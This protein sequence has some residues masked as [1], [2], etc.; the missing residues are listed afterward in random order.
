MSKKVLV[1]GAAG[2]IGSHTLIELI[3]SGAYEVIALDNFSNST[4][5]ALERVKKI[6]NSEFKVLET[7]LCNKEHCF[8]LLDKVGKID[9]VI[10]FAA[11]KAVGESVLNPL[12]YYTNNLVSLL[13]LLEYCKVNQITNFV[14]SSS[15]SIYGNADE[16]PVTETSPIKKAESPYANTKQMGEEIIEH[17]LKSLPQHNAVILRYFN[18]VGAHLSG[19]LGEYPLGKPN[20]LVPIITQTA[21]GKNNLTVFGN[22]YDTRDG[23]CIRDYIHVSDIA[24]AHVLAT[25]FLLNNKNESQVSLF[26]LGTGNGVTVLEAIT[27]FEKVAKLKLKYTLGARRAGD[28]VAVYAN[29]NLAIKKLNWKIKYSINDMMLSA[30]KWQQ[31][32][33]NDGI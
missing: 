18:P 21:I 20:N 12:Q 26:N 1:T 32:I 10:H 2:Y 8:S 5:Q 23:T 24:N 19:Q 33:E 17:F 9:V 3:E 15:C 31:T 4:K 28:V 14:F 25:N 13:N 16:L 11:L 22:D 30:W 7:D 27:A 6:T 29:N